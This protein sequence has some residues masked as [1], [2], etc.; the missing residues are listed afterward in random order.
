MGIK[1]IRNPPAPDIW[2]LHSHSKYSANDA[3]P[4]VWAMV[5]RAAQMR[6]PALGLTD[7]GNSAGTVKLYKACAES[8][9]KPF[10]GS[11]FYVV[12][13]REAHMAATKKRVA[14]RTEDDA[15]NAKRYHMCVVAFTSEG[16]ANLVNLQTT[17]HLNFHG[18]PIIDLRDITALGEASRL[19][20]LAG[21]SGCYFGLPVTLLTQGNEAATRSI[22]ATMAGAFDRFYVELQNHEIDHGD[23]WNDSLVADAML[24][25]AQEMGL[26]CVLTQDSHYVLPSERN[27]HES[28]KRLVA[29]G[30]DPDEAVFPGDGFHLADTDWFLAHHEGERLRAGREGLADLLAAHDLSI[31][32]LDKYHYNIP[33]TVADPDAELLKYCTEALALIRESGQRLGS[34]YDDRLLDELEI[35]RDT[36]MAGYILTVG[37]CT[38][39]LRDNQVFYQ[40]RG[41]ASGSIVCWLRGITQLDPLRWNLSFERFISRDRTKPPDVDLDIEHSRRAE[42]IEWLRSRFAVHQI[43]TWTKYSLKGDYDEGGEPTGSGSLLRRYFT[44]LNAM[45]V[46]EVGWNEIPDEDKVEMYRLSDRKLLSHYGVHP[47]GLV[48]TSTEEELRN[49][50]PLMK[51]ASSETMVTQYD[52]KDVEALGLVKLDV[53][54]LKTLTVLHIALDN[55]GRDYRD[56]FDWIP[57]TDGPTYRMIGQ[58]TTDGVFQ[59][60]GY[61]ARRGCQDLKPTKI[62]DIVAA[63]ALFRPATMKSGATESY[64]A[65]KKGT[66]RVPRR[67][68]V[69]MENTKDTFGIMLFQEQVISILRDLGMDP[70]DLTLF[71]KAVKSSNDNV[72]WARGIIEQF[73]PQLQAE[74]DRQGF[75]PEDW[76]W[77][78]NAIE[79][80]GEYGFNAAHATAYG[81]TAYRCAYLLRN[82]PVEFYAALLAVAAGAS[83]QKGEKQSKEQR[84]ASAARRDGI[85]LLRPDVNYSGRTYSVDPKG[86]GIRRGLVAIKGIGDTNAQAI[87]D[88]RG[89]V[90]F[91]S[92]EDF[93]NRV[94]HRKLNGI[95]PFLMQGDKT[96]GKLGLLVEY[97][98]FESLE[99]S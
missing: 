44:R 63:M 9:I 73:K 83:K 68:S 80:F 77:L 19:R 60:E 78:W 12:R 88:G 32:A 97:G 39:W 15:R 26:P 75:T 64:I 51:V 10:P 42:F 86:R 66:E 55:L 76:G 95:K 91:T 27:D 34:R 79:G 57:L 8:G 54:G 43:G 35:I 13:D 18:K 31:P 41:S 6:Q 87:V 85:R 98:A 2:N 59:L 3:L 67:H 72:E 7:H 4:E 90:P 92:L 37:E 48:I 96:V 84:Y 30:P 40:A 25:I 58:G 45:G 70:D 46:G 28:L 56:G 89:D 82:H 20:G 65:R 99:E 17:S 14:D 36:G 11:E 1:V 74:A 5:A 33:L 47:A 71:L 22:L 24:G 23:G 16:Y 29:F 38:D 81:L 62:A 50:V 21:T 49:L 94:D 69:I 93:A 53:L 52:M 61:A